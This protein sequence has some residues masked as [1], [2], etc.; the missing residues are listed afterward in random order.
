MK[1]AF[2]RE[3]AVASLGSEELLAEMALAYAE[4]REDML[5]QLLAA[6][7]SGDMQA[8]R[9]KAHWI[10]GCLV[11]LHAEP[12]ASAAKELELL[13]TDDASSETLSGGVTRLTEE[14][15]RLGL[16]LSRL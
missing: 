14:M 16:E 12:A 7:E 9:E 3:R 13:A 8:V 11:Y 5:S 1:P 6:V 4:E 15:D 10:K 2:D